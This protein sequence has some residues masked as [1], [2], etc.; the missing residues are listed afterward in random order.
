MQR[1][2]RQLVNSLEIFVDADDCLALI[3]SISHEKVLLIVSDELGE[4][5]VSRVQDLQQVMRIYV[6]C[7]TAEQAENWS[8]EVPKI[9]QIY[10]DVETIIEQIR[11]HILE[12]ERRILSFSL[13]SSR[14][15]PKDEPTFLV[16]QLLKEIL[17]DSDEMNDARED[18]LHFARREYQNNPE[19]LA[20]IDVFAKEYQRDKPLQFFQAQS[21]LFK[22][23]KSFVDGE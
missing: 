9:E 17:L 3:N 2:L 13:I 18:F 14:A 8:T 5:V 19:Q 11:G 7:Q 15:N 21:F 22:V 4:P 10:T 23:K 20:A 6:L 16:Q 1:E 12:E